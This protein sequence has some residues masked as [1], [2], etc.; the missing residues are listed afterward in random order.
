MNK[1]LSWLLSDIPE[2][3]R[4]KVRIN[5]DRK[6][7][8]ILKGRKINIEYLQ[9]LESENKDIIS[10]KDV[11]L[12]LS[13]N[14]TRGGCASGTVNRIKKAIT[15]GT[16]AKPLSDSKVLQWRLKDIKDMLKNY[17]QSFI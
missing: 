7:S 9:K 17:N 12:I 8:H 13:Y 4:R 1:I 15:N 16:F 3:K 2:P 14:L 5:Y 11:Y 10:M 6:Q